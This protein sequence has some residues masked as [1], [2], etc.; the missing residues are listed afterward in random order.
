[1]DEWLGSSETS[2]KGGLLSQKLLE[3]LGLEGAGKDN[4]MNT[5][6]SADDTADDDP[7]PSY[8]PS[9]IHSCPSLLMLRFAGAVLEP[10]SDTSAQPVLAQSAISRHNDESKCHPSGAWG[11]A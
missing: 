2:S 8:Y 5:R 4:A 1:M 3:K 11:E 7:G 9:S 6:T 10:Q